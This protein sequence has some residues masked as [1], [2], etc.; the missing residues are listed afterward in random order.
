MMKEKLKRLKEA[1]KSWN[2]DNF[3]QLD[4][5]VTE[6][7]RNSHLLMLGMMVEVCQKEQRLGGTR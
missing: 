7:P 5:K 6:L 3:G 2:L 4:T 1:L